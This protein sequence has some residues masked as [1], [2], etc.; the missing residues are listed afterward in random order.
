[1]NRCACSLSFEQHIGVYARG[2]VQSPVLLTQT[3]SERRKRKKGER[4]KTSGKNQVAG[5]ASTLVKPCL[6]PQT[7]KEDLE[8]NQR[9]VLS[10]HLISHPSVTVYT[11]NFSLAIPNKYCTNNTPKFPPYP[12]V[13]AMTLIFLSVPSNTYYQPRITDSDTRL[14]NFNINSKWKYVHALFYVNI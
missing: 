13:T 14:R 12:S 6:F 1:M 10:L 5:N 7:M 4:C 9:S 3:Q 2:L 11:V 8:R